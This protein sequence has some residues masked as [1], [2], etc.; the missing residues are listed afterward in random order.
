MTSLVRPR[1]LSRRLARPAY[2]PALPAL[3]LLFLLLWPSS[4]SLLPLS[5]AQSITFLD[6]QPYNYTTIP[7]NTSTITIPITY[8]YANYTLLIY[9]NATRLTAQPAYGPAYTST[10]VDQLPPHESDSFLPAA[11]TP[12]SVLVLPLVISP[13]RGLTMF[14]SVCAFYGV[15][16]AC[17]VDV[18][19]TEAAGATV[20]YSVYYIPNINIGT[21]YDSALAAGTWEYYALWI[22][23]AD[24]DVLFI[25]TPTT[26]A[27]P[28]HNTSSLGPPAATPDVDLWLAA[29]SSTTS[30]LVPIFPT[31]DNGAVQYQHSG[32]QEVVELDA[33][34]GFQDGLYI[35]GVYAPVAGV[36][37]YSLLLQGAVYQG[38]TGGVEVSMFAIV[39]ALVVLVLCLF[40]AA[41]LIARRRRSYIRDLLQIDSPA[42]QMELMHRIQ[43]RALAEGRTVTPAAAEVYHGATESQIGRLPSHVYA[44][45]EMSDEDAKC[46]ICL[47]EYVSKVSTIKV[48]HCGHV[49]HEE[50]ASHPRTHIRPLHGIAYTTRSLT[51]RLLVLLLRC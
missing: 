2:F 46:T 38:V 16:G 11:F 14:A 34:G 50:S 17:T 31:D 40:S 27:T 12:L 45:G 20:A 22:T 4:S 36:S 51:T 25:L 28:P 10:A 43:V 39:A 30:P 41:A 5:A 19:F 21:T 23:Q 44:E 8:Q 42:A 3:C 13:A 26:Y 48:L 24:L 47:E 32:G 29:V 7:A 33:D 18:N 15:G 1:P 6:N 37:G 9:T 35:I 49:F